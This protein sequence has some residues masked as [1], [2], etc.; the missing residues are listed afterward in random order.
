MEFIETTKGGRKLSKDGFIYIK[1]KTLTNGRTYWE[2]TQRCSGNGWNVKITLDAADRFVAQTNQHSHAVYPKSNDLLK[3]RAGIKRFVKDTAEKMQKIITANIAGLPENVLERLPNVETIRRDVRR[4]RPNNHPAIP[5][6]YY[7]QFAIPQNY[8]MDVLGQQ[9]PVYD[10]GRPDRILLFD[11]DEGFCFLSNSSPVQFMQLYTVDGLTSH[12]NI[13]G[14][15][16]LLPNKRRATYVE[17]LTEVQR[18]THNAMSHS[19]MTDFESSILSALNKIYPG[20]P[21]VGK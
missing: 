18:L 12:Q 6:I 11:T 17:M 20:I 8:T 2:C 4:N 14:G 19:L 1:N 3:A 13:V 10:N 5:D 9:F 15:Y 21:Q 7:T 16:A